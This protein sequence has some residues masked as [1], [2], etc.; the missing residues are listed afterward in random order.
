MMKQ[1]NS[2][3]L[4]KEK[5]IVGGMLLLGLILLTAALWQAKE[6]EPSGWI[7]ISGQVE[8][9]IAPIELEKSKKEME[10]G[11]EKG[12]GQGKSQGRGQGQVQVQ[13]E[14]EGQGQGQGQG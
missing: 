3:F 6:A 4:R 1:T 10:Q 11:Q 12:Q 13:G 7:E 9:T 8:Q 5:A 2:S 14:G